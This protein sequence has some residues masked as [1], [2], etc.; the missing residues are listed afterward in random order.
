MES[1]IDFRDTQY[2]DE[3]TFPNNQF[4]A[5]PKIL[6]QFSRDLLR[7]RCARK[8]TRRAQ[9]A[10]FRQWREYGTRAPTIEVRLS[11]PTRRLYRAVSRRYR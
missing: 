7:R 11:G 6:S 4:A 2:R 3:I 5:P 8:R 9:R 1:K 10:F